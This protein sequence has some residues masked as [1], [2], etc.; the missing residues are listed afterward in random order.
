MPQLYTFLDFEPFDPGEVRRAIDE[1]RDVDIPVRRP[2]MGLEINRETHATLHILFKDLN[3]GE[4]INSSDVA[5]SSYGTSNFVITHVTHARNERIQISDSF[6]N[7]YLHTYG[8]QPKMLTVRGVLLKSKNFPWK[9]EW[10]YN[11][12]RVFRASRTIEDA[13]RVYLT[14]EET[15]YEGHMLS[16]Q[17]VDQADTPNMSPM[18]F[19]M[20][21]TNVIYADPPGAAAF[22]PVDADF[23]SSTR[24]SSSEYVNAYGQNLTENLYSFDEHG[25]IVV[26]SRERVQAEELEARLAQ[27]AAITALANDLMERLINHPLYPG[28]HPDSRQARARELVE[29]T[30]NTA[31]ELIESGRDAAESAF[32][33]MSGWVSGR[34]RGDQSSRRRRVNDGRSHGGDTDTSD[35]NSEPLITEEELAGINQAMDELFPGGGFEW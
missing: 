33:E 11:Y 17:V 18:Q 4:M 13:A 21:L 15:I 24:A 35:I 26:E 31:R 19:V 34:D 8:E 14:V 32:E 9:T 12:D 6:A 22:G 25:N 10:L 23:G 16:C 28:I 20:L 3:A 29:H 1:G 5:G 2:F 27:E 30:M 7:L